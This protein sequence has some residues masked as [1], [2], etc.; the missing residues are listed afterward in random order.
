MKNSR[1]AAVF[2]IAAALLSAC[3]DQGDDRLKEKAH[4]EGQVQASEQLKKDKELL[5]EQTKKQIELQNDQLR[6]ERQAIDRRATQMEKSLSKRLAYY[7]DNSGHYEGTL[8]KGSDTFGIRISLFPNISKYADSRIRTPAEI[9]DDLTN[10]SYSAQ[11]VQWVPGT[12]IS[13]ADGC[14][15]EG[16]RPNMKTGTLNIIS[17]QCPSSYY[18]SLDRTSISGTA[19]PSSIPVIFEIYANKNPAGR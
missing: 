16:L 5:E 19:Q 2:L 8:T 15:V 3:E 18:L 6:K 12:D 9:E 4:I 17:S 10:L 13:A 11:I 14:R 7:E 1:T